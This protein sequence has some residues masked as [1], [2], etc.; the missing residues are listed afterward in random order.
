MNSGPWCVKRNL[1]FAGLVRGLQD[2][3]PFLFCWLP[4]QSQRATNG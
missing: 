3:E 2:S 1:N 4:E